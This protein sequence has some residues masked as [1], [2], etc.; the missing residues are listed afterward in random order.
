[1][2]M[3]SFIGGG[4]GS[5]FGNEKPPMKRVESFTTY[6][7]L[8]IKISLQSTTFKEEWKCYTRL[9]FIPVNLWDLL[10]GGRSPPYQLF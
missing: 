7:M 9:C 4:N 10:L 8:H 1:M 6:F 2:I 5:T 3:I